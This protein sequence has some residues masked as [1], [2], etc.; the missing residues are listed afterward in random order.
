MTFKQEIGLEYYFLELD[1]VDR[2]NLSR[3]RFGNHK[4]PIAEGC[5]LPV[6][7]TKYCNLCNLQDKGDEL[8]YTLVCPAFH[9]FRKLYLTMYYTYCFKNVTTI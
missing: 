3:F 6:Q 5:Y 8:H 9:D 7:I 1:F 4:L 2:R